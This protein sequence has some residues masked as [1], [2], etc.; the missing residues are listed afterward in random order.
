MSNI[1]V[2][3]DQTDLRFTTW[4]LRVSMVCDFTFVWTAMI[5][6]INYFINALHFASIVP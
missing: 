3:Q 4:L 6:L 2:D 1:S 5:L